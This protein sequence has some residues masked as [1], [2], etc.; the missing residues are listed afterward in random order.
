MAFLASL[1]ARA[2]G[3]QTAMMCPT[4]VLAD[5]HVRNF[6]NQFASL[7]EV[8]PETC[9]CPVHVAPISMRSW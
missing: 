7:P 1:L 9:H 8:Q 2:D 6:D 3:F 5:Q 4:E